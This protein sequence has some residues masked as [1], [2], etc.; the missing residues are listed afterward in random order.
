M[1][2]HESGLASVWPEGRVRL[3]PNR[4][5]RVAACTMSPSKART[6]ALGRAVKSSKRFEAF[7]G[8]HVVDRGEPGSPGS[9]GASPYQRRW[10]N[11]GPPTRRPVPLTLLSRNLFSER[12]AG[13]V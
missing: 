6:E 2:A 4:A 5:C 3:R 7:L 10:R 13:N 8:V 9:D 1:L 12:F 11:A